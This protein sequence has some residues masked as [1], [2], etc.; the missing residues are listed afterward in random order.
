[1][2]I[3][4]SRPAIANSETILKTAQNQAWWCT[5]IILALGRQGRR[6][7]SSRPPN[8]GPSSQKEQTGQV[9]VPPQKKDGVQ[10]Y[11]I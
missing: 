8:E 2:D 1:V 4:S 11:S 6:V 5:P 9:M 7:S 10:V 3:T